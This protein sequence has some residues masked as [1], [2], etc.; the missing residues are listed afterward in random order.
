MLLSGIITH[1]LARK[2]Q[3]EAQVEQA[4]ANG[5]ERVVV[6]AAGYDSLAWRLHLKYPDVDFV[7]LDHPATQ[8][9]KRKE[10]GNAPNFLLQPID[11]VTE[12]PSLALSKLASAQ[13]HSTAFVVEGLTMYLPAERVAELLRDLSKL[14]GPKGS[15][16]FTFLERDESGS[17]AFR[18]EN[19]LVA[20]W[21]R[22]RSEPFLWGISRDELPAFLQSSQLQLLQLDDHQVLR[23]D[24]LV[25]RGIDQLPLAEGELIGTASP[26]P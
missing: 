23:R 19:P 4:I 24:Q 20:R 10:L 22:A 15:I 11:L 5:C 1:Y 12:L 14:A 18:G 13:P 26:L 7:E 3:I 21:L 9:I 16:V 25:P 17:I 6:I 8:Q 2:R